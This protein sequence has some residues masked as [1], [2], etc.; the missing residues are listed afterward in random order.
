MQ[1]NW[2]SGPIPDRPTS[3]IYNCFPTVFSG[4]FKT[5]G[6]NTAQRRKQDRQCTYNVTLGRVR[7]TTVAVEKQ[8]LR[9]YLIHTLKIYKC[10]FVA[11]GI[12]HEMRMCSITVYS[13]I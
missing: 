13:R 1:H 4:L 5:P 12:Q 9:K 6:N 11:L 3:L 2:A 7:V 8:K 10:V